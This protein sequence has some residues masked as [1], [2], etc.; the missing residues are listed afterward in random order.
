[1]W[2]AF[3]VD[4]FY[5]AVVHQVLQ[6]LHGEIRNLL[7]HQSKTFLQSIRIVHGQTAQNLFFQDQ[8]LSLIF[9]GKSIIQT[10]IDEALGSFKVAAPFCFQNIFRKFNTKDLHFIMFRHNC[11]HSLKRDYNGFIIS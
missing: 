5:T 10:N 2:N 3:D 11:L 6:F 4:P 1:M 7:L 8:T 9:G